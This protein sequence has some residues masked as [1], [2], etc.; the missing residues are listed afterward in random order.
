MCGHTHQENTIYSI[1]LHQNLPFF[2]KNQPKMAIFCQKWYFL[3]KKYHFLALI[4]VFCVR[5]VSW[6]SRYPIVRVLDSKE[7]VLHA[8]E[9]ISQLFQ[10]H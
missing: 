1:R 8:I 6:C 5:V 10:G 4:S 2:I 7:E 9:A 3:A